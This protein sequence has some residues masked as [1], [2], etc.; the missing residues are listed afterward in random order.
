MFETLVDFES[1]LN[2]VKRWVAAVKDNGFSAGH[3]VGATLTKNVKEGG[4]SYVCT[5]CCAT[6]AYLVREIQSNS[7]KA[8]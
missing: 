5:I 8:I 2:S 4:G 1:R 6:E 3:G 7:L